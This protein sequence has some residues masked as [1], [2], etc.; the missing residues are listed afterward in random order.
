MDE[1]AAAAAVATMDIDDNAGEDSQLG[2]TSATVH[3]IDNK[4]PAVESTAVNKE[5]VSDAPANQDLG[6]ADP[7]VISTAC[8]PRS[9]H[10]AQPL[11]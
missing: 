3:V 4:Q 5:N 8:T 1:L 6:A 7:K 10:L 2:S 11:T 9:T